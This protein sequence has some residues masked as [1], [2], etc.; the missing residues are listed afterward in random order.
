M[1]V[2]TPA[3]LELRDV[4]LFYG[5]MQA[6]RGVSLRVAKG[7]IVALLG[8]NGAGKTSTLNAIAGA[9]PVK[10][11][12]ILFSGERIDGLT[13]ER[14]VEAGISL[15][16]ERRRLFPSMSV[17]DNL[18]LGAYR[19]FRKDDKREI[20][21]DLSLVF[22]LFP[23]LKERVGQPSGTLSGGQQQMVAVG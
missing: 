6:L 9:T 7:E 16:P 19:R 17:L 12:E 11:G 14:L 2:D 15:V 21:R 3:M 20:E 4:C 8:T 23:I 13:P 1:Q 22:E 18:I 10:K 5:G